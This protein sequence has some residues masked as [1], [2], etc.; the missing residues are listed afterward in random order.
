MGD[1]KRIW[2]VA[3]D[4]PIHVIKEDVYKWNYP[5]DLEELLEPDTLI[6]QTPPGYEIF[7][8]SYYHGIDT[9]I[10]FCRRLK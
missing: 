6:R 2:Q 4:E 1:I 8:T 3:K 5:E 7:I 9:V 10:Y